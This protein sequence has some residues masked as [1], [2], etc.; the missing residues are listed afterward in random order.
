MSVI[1]TKKEPLYKNK[2]AKRKKYCGI[3]E[4]GW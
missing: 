4:R 2:A 1:T 3:D